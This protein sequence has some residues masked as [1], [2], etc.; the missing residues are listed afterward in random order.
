M[1]TFKCNCGKTVKFDNVTNSYNVGEAMKLTGWTY[2]SCQYEGMACWLCPD[3]AEK[4]KELARQLFSVIGSPYYYWT[5]LIPK[6]ERDRWCDT[7]TKRKRLTAEEAALNILK[8]S[9][10]GM[11]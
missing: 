6:E 8:K 7:A 1:I 2:G 3:C 4:A 10:K 9:N 11:L 5:N